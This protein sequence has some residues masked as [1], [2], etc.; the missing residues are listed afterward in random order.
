[1]F[2]SIFFLSISAK[3]A[4]PFIRIKAFDA[5]KAGTKEGQSPVAHN[6]R[7]II[8][9]SAHGTVLKSYHKTTH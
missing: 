1:M 9:L 7:A 5:Q 2:I 4:H 3:V 6:L 8:Q